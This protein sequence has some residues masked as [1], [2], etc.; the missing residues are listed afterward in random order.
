[1]QKAARHMGATIAGSVRTLVQDYFFGKRTNGRGKQASTK[2][3][4]TRT[5]TSKPKVKLI[6]KYAKTCNTGK[7]YYAGIL[8]ASIYGAAAVSI[9]KS[10]L[11]DMLAGALASHPITARCKAIPHC[12]KML[13]FPLTHNPVYQAA[14]APVLRW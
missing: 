9:P 14:A 5:K 11:K 13:T 6:K 12:L 3:I 8:T 2:V 7:V 10:T 1:M 4:V